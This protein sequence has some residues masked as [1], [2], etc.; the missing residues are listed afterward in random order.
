MRDA[1]CVFQA[2]TWNYVV[3]EGKV[4]VTQR[5]FVVPDN[6]LCLVGAQLCDVFC[7]GGYA[8][9]ADGGGG[10]V[11]A[12]EEESLDLVRVSEG[13]VGAV[14]AVVEGGVGDEGREEEV[15]VGLES[16]VGSVIGSTCAGMCAVCRSCF[17]CIVQQY[18]HRDK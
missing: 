18:K 9:V 1:L 13:D 10:D 15:Q 5:A 14:E 7:C 2:N 4:G 11:A 17:T 8:V 12:A 16:C 3:E 6:G